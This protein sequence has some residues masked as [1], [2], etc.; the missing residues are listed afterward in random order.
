MSGLFMMMLR[1]EIVKS[2]EGG[3]GLG[4][5]VFWGGGAMEFRGGLFVGLEVGLDIELATTR[6]GGSCVIG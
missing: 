1:F 2:G 6:E 4:S 3:G 5:W